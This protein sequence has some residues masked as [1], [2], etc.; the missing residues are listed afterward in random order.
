MRLFMG[1][2]LLEILND[3]TVNFHVL[4]LSYLCIL[5]ISAKFAIGVYSIYFLFI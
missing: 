5:C 3:A 4:S 2:N 1:P